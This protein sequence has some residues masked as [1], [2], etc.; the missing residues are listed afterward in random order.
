MTT[1]MQETTRPQG[2]FVDLA[3]R[4]FG[5]AVV[6]IMFAFL[7]NNYLSFWRDWPGLSDFFAYQ[8][9]FGG[10]G[11]QMSPEAVS[12]AWIQ[13]A[14]Y[15]AALAGAIGLVLWRPERGLRAD[16]ASMRAL[17]AYIIRAAFWAVLLV[18]VADALISF[19]RIE[20]YLEQFVGTGLTNDLGLSHFR[21]TYVHYPLI[22]VGFVIAF[23]NRSLGFI[24]LASL[25]VMAEML[26]VLARF[27]FSYEQAFMA[28]LV[29]FWYAAIFLFGSAYT[30]LH[31]GHVRVDV[32]YSGFNARRKAWVNTLGAIFLGGP[33]CWIV[34]TM[35]LANNLSVIS[36]PIMSYEISQSSFGM[37]VKYLLAG[38]L[39]VF[40][41]T[42]LLEFMAAL[43]RN[44]GVLLREDDALER[45]RETA[46]VEPVHA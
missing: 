11:P 16:A 4:G 25:V 38:Y 41:L 17:A 36:G 44:A 8:G 35:G 31:E 30:L 40:A 20:G 22:L 14:I 21:G 39:L 32:L 13:F 27:I 37:Y 29:R 6:G 24:W 45:V 26:I 42:M 3:L 2:D 28:D 15:V 23:F 7:I 33:V 1:T 46:H 19:L 12:L 10:T 9:W 5:L 43:L 18:G 34:L